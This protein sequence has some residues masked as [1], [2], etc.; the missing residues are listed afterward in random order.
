M[1]KNVDLILHISPD[2]EDN[3]VMLK[4]N[5]YLPKLSN[6]KKGL[7]HID[8]IHRIWYGGNNGFSGRVFIGSF[9]RFDLDAFITFL[10]QLDWEDP[11]GL[12]LFYLYE[13]MPLFDQWRLMDSNKEG[14]VRDGFIISTNPRRVNRDVVRRYLAEES[15][16]AQGLPE[17]VLERAIAGSLNFGIY[18][19]ATGAQVGFA[20]VVTDKATF[21]YLCDV[22]VLPEYRGRGL[23]K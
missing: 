22:F 11:E 15:Y 4:I 12:Q 8:E 3:G 10:S 23:S 13:D 7:I 14:L 9:Y 16:W 18:D 2:D 21:A 20:R 1:P 17:D 5:D 6:G 19:E